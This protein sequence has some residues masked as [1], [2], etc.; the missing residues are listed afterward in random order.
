MKNLGRVLIFQRCSTLLLAE[1]EARQRDLW[2]AKKET[3][4]CEFIQLTGNSISHMYLVILELAAG[5]A[6]MSYLQ[7]VI[8]YMQL[9]S[10]ICLTC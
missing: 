3:P 5:G 10:I 9:F 8:P 7:I 2:K 4:E 6:R 1:V